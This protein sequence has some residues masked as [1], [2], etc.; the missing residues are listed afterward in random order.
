MGD[1]TL[2]SWETNNPA[3]WRQATATMSKAQAKKDERRLNRL[4]GRTYKAIRL[5]E[6]ESWKA[7]YHT[8]PA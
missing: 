6:L 4:S 1:W 5:S 8:R 7:Q 2:V 3:N